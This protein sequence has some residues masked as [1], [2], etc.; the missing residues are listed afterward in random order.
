MTITLHALNSMSC[1]LWHMHTDACSTEQ[2]RSIL[3]HM[4][5]LFR[6]G[7]VQALLLVMQVLVHRAV[8]VALVA[9]AHDAQRR[10]RL[11]GCSLQER[12]HGMQVP[13][14]CVCGPHRPLQ[15]GP[16]PAVRMQCTL[17]LLPSICGLSNSLSFPFWGPPQ[18]VRPVVDEQGLI[19][20]PTMHKYTET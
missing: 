11:C 17:G 3:H 5:R 2:A 4:L 1:R 8:P 16:A 20:T 18:Q 13:W 12:P 19:N 15:A 10:S 7:S 14:G 6:S 9:R